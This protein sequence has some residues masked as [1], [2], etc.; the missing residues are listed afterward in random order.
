ML[1]KTDSVFAVTVQQIWGQSGLHVIDFIGF[2]ESE[3]AAQRAIEH[4]DYVTYEE[5]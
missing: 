1:W 5:A 4:A 3:A 2:F